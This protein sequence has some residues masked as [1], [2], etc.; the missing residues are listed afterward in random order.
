VDAVSVEVAAGA[1]VVLGGAGVAITATYDATEALTVQTMPNGI[2]ATH[3]IDPTGDVT[4]VSYAKGGFWFDDRQDSNIHGQSR[5]HTGPS[6]WEAYGYDPAGRLAVVW[7][8][9]NGQ[10]CVQRGYTFDPNSNRTALQA[11]PANQQ[12]TCPPSTSPTST[13]YNYDAADRLQPTGIASGLTYDA[14]GRITTLPSALAG[15]TTTTMGYYTTDVI[16]SQTQGSTTRSWTLDPARRLRAGALTG[17]PTK[18]NHYD[19]V[20]DAP[21]W[22]DEGDGTRTRYV[23]A[24]DGNLVAVVSSSGI[25]VTDVRYQVTGLHGD[26]IATTSPGAATP[27]GAF[28]D[29]DEYGNPRGT[30]PPARYGWL[31]GKQRSADT[32][33]GL[34]LMGVRVYD[35]RSGRFLQVD[36]VESGCANK[37]DYAYQD[38]VN[39]F[40][41]DGRQCSYSPDRWPGVFDFR[42]A[43]RWHDWCYRTHARSRLGCDNGFYYRMKQ[44]CYRYHG[45]IRWWQFGKLQRRNWCLRLAFVYYLAVRRLGAPAYYL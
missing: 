43:C 2:T 31:G 17:Q 15:G 28:L 1:V 22:I 44:S 16:A 9:R 33:A 38:P 26:I 34:I 39:G 29:F 45:D 12:G 42:S 30:T 25:T 4:K 7:E 21:A 41:L 27:D 20:G 11:W 14:F 36:P 10:P 35:P 19:G 18:I 13:S 23:T 6:G 32:L 40:D 8:Q 37:Y 3:T 24:F 5:W